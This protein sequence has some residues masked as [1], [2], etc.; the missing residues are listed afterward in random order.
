MKTQK[1][2][3]KSEV[4]NACSSS[5]KGIELVKLGDG[6]GEWK[7]QIKEYVSDGKLYG[8]PGQRTCISSTNFLMDGDAFAIFDDRKEELGKV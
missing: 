3:N 4:I 7:Y 2:V 8:R 6:W 1:L 5:G